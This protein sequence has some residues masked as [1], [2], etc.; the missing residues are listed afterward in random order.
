MKRLFFQCL[1]AG[2]GIMLLSPGFV[3]AQNQ[4]PKNPGAVSAKDSAT[5]REQARAALT[6]SKLEIVERLVERTRNVVIPTER[7]AWWLIDSELEYAKKQ[8][9]KAALAAMQTLIIHPKPVL[10]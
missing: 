1:L 9:A 10:V 5:L 2:L 8:Y 6:A 4:A 3:V 7:T